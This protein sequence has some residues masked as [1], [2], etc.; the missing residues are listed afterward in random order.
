[1]KKHELMGELEKTFEEEF[2]WKMDPKGD[3]DPE[4]TIQ[5]EE[6]NEA[7]QYAIGRANKLYGFYYDFIKY[8]WK[9][10]AISF[11][12]L[13]LSIM[14]Q[15]AFLYYISTES[16]SLMFEFGLNWVEGQSALY[17]AQ[18]IVTFQCIKCDI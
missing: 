3:R 9:S 5:D 15:F 17:L 6:K 14:I 7:I 1:M 18:F 8:I 12:L 16:L 4:D 13:G 10:L 2:A 11:I